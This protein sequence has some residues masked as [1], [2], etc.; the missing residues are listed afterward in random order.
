MA[1][2]PEDTDG[3]LS[4]D[5]IQEVRRAF[6]E[7]TEKLYESQK[8]VDD[9]ERKAK[10]FFVWDRQ[11]ALRHLESVREEHEGVQKTAVKD[12]LGLVIDEVDSIE[13]LDS[14]DN[15]EPDK[16]KDTG[17]LALQYITEIAPLG[18]RL[19]EEVDAKQIVE[20]IMARPLTPEGDPSIKAANEMLG[21]LRPLPPLTAAPKPDVSKS[22]A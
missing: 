15:I 2:N 6:S 18:G 5:E 21:E 20:K 4:Q 8:A 11:S 9:A 14:I 7:M 12:L 17:F 16:I 10:A 22:I 3:I 13:N 1:D 19:P